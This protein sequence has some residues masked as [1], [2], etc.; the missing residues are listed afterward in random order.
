MEKPLPPVQIDSTKCPPCSKLICVGT[1]PAGSLEIGPNGKPGTIDIAPCTQCG[2][3]ADL[4]PA[5]AI[6][7]RDGQVPSQK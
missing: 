5:K 3:C 6:T 7:I 4:C 2:V 1:C